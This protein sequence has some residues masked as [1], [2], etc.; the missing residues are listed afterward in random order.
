MI[1]IPT[2]DKMEQNTTKETSNVKLLK[3]LGTYSII[4]IF[5]LTL[6]SSFFLSNE[7]D[8][9]IK[10]MSLNKEKM[11]EIFYSSPNNLKETN[12]QIAEGNGEKEL[13]ED[14]QSSTQ[15]SGEEAYEGLYENK[16]AI[17]DAGYTL[18]DSSEEVLAYQKLLY[19]LGYLKDLPEGQNKGEFESTTEVAVRDFQSN[20]K[21]EVTGELN[22]ETQESL[23]LKPIEFKTGQSGDEIRDYQMIL[24][25]LDHLKQYPDG[26]F[27]S[28]TETAVK[29]YQEEQN[30]NQTGIL[31]QKTQK[32]LKSE[33]LEYKAGKRGE[34]IFEYQ[35][36]L[37]NLGYLHGNPDGNLNSINVAAIKQYQENNNLEQTGYL[38]ITTQESL[39]KPL[40]QQEE[41]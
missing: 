20:E 38:D 28:L 36:I 2:I 32:S 30:I 6:T 9:K 4:T 11:E 22:K 17:N 37:I 34:P 25:Y 7:K 40:N 41:F 27:G 24:Y 12:A 1:Y 29:L 15:T 33:T 5:V 23:L 8:S 3:S 14:E 16:P 10:N 35:D 19:Y 18:G 39:K 31:D 21:L 13:G 26:S